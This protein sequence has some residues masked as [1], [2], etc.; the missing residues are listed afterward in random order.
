MGT[1]IYLKGKYLKH[2]LKYLD[3]LAYV[4][5]IQLLLSCLL[6]VDLQYTVCGICESSWSAPASVQLLSIL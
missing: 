5:T 4:H 3:C 6:S 2:F 1:V